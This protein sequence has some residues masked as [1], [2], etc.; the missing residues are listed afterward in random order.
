MSRGHTTAS[1][2]PRPKDGASVE[3]IVHAPDTTRVWGVPPWSCSCTEFAP[4][5]GVIAL[6]AAGK[7]RPRL[8][9]HSCLTA[10]FGMVTL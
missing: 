7:V 6:S 3:S 9:D 8:D 1:A 2:E 10:V 4:S 5:V